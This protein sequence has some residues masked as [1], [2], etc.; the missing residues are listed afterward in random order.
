LTT[1]KSNV[2]RREEWLKLN[3]PFKDRLARLEA[4]GYTRREIQK[5]IKSTNIA[6]RKRRETLEGMQSHERQEK[7]RS[8]KTTL[9]NFFKFRRPISDDDSVD[10]LWDSAQSPALKSS[11]C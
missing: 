1:T 8:F 7:L 4:S 5:T 6:R 9:F 11:Y 2:H 3:F 10:T